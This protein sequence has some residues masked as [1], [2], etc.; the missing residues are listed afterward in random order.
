MISASQ[1]PPRTA[2]HRG[3]IDNVT[4]AHADFRLP[5]QA[6]EVNFLSIK[7]TFNAVSVFSLN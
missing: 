3:A 4:S 7:C 1:T 5:S 2:K 6:D